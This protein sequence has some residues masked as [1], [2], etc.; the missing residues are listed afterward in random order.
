MAFDPQ[1]LL[2][3]NYC[4]VHVQLEHEHQSQPF[5]PFLIQ[6][7]SGMV[8]NENN[9]MDDHFTQGY[10]IR[11]SCE[12]TVAAMEPEAWF[13]GNNKV[14]IRVPVGL[15]GDFFLGDPA[16]RPFC[17][18]LLQFPEEVTLI[19]PFRAP[20]VDE[21]NGNMAKGTVQQTHSFMIVQQL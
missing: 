15:F 5:G 1:S 10:L 3:N 11:V 9:G 20:L 2:A 14:F 13:L 7:W 17:Y 16:L 19:N 8:G 6:G 12:V 18:Y 4:T 21:N